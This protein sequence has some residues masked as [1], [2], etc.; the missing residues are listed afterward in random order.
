MASIGQP[1]EVAN[2]FC[3]HASPISGRPGKHIVI[4]SGGQADLDVEHCHYVVAVV[5]QVLSERGR[6]HLV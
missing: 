3:D 1:G 4:G 5:A 2:V 6:V